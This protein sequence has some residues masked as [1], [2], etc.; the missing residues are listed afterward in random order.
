MSDFNNDNEVNQRL[1]I[2]KMY[3]N[4]LGES[5]KAYYKDVYNRNNSSDTIKPLFPITL[6]TLDHNQ[7][8]TNKLELKKRDNETIAQLKRRI[9][10]SRSD[11]RNLCSN[12]CKLEY[13]LTS[14]NGSH[15]KIITEQNINSSN[16]IV[17]IDIETGSYNIQYNK[18]NYFLNKI[19]FVKGQLFKWNQLENTIIRNNESITD[20]V[21][22]SFIHNAEVHFY[23][24]K[25]S[26]NEGDN[27]LVMICG[28]KSDSNTPLKDTSINDSGYL[29]LADSIS[30]S[31]PRAIS[32]LS[33]LPSSLSFFSYNII[34]EKDW[35]LTKNLK[36]VILEDF[37]KISQS[38]LDTFMNAD[39]IEGNIPSLS[40]IPR[41]SNT[42]NK[43]ILGFLVASNDRQDYDGVYYENETE[44]TYN[45]SI[46]SSNKNNALRKQALLDVKLPSGWKI[47]KES[48]KIVGDSDNPVLL[49]TVFSFIIS[50][51]IYIGV[52]DTFNL[53]ENRFMYLFGFTTCILFMYFIY[54][55][56]MMLSEKRKGIKQKSKT[57][58]IIFAT[59]SGLSLV[60][61]VMLAIFQRNSRLD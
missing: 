36:V 13:N 14:K 8:Q 28:I 44:I 46:I 38:T 40:S 22:S 55:L 59:L 56:A 29:M 54:F 37:V 47:V 53:G 10:K 20:D 24:T 57:N 6:H 19:C 51:I 42:E 34:P 33:L 18:K 12:T 1:N 3:S 32:M 4:D 7:N 35:G 45:S 27:H 11:K 25:E 9:V 21:Q 50:S 2:I 26:G 39:F 43:P 61:I 58:M 60:I 48:K 5:I 15:K 17:C 23:F 16:G 52:M 31:N 41:P 30:N 49:W